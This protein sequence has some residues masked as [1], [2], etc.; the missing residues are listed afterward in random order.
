MKRELPHEEKE[1]RKC[2]I[3]GGSFNPR[4]PNQY[5]C[6]EFDCKMEM[7]K[8]RTFWAKKRRGETPPW[9]RNGTAIDSEDETGTN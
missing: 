1:V 8:H 5:L 4:Q 3:C 9:Q 6:G 2:Y 7:M